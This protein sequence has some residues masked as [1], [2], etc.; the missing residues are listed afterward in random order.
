MPCVLD[1]CAKNP[2]CEQR[3]ELL[4]ALPRAWPQGQVTGL[5]VRGGM[6]LDLTWSG[7]RP[8]SAMLK[9]AVDG[10]YSLRYPAGSRIVSVRSGDRTMAVPSDE[11][12]RLNLQAGQVYQVTFGR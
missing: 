8:V 1:A 7:G 10:S 11:S 5:K 2:L 4:P 9:P 6:E 12:A 3:D